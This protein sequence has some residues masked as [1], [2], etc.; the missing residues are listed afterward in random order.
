[1]LHPEPLGFLTMQMPH[2]DRR[3]VMISEV[4]LS[5]LRGGL[6][7]RG[8]F[9]PIDDPLVAD[10]N[11]Y[12]TNDLLQSAYAEKVSETEYIIGLGKPFP[13][14]RFKVQ[15][16][17]TPD[18][19]GQFF[20]IVE[21]E[22]TGEQAKFTYTDIHEPLTIGGIT[23]IVVGIAGGLCALSLIVGLIANWNCKKVEVTYGFHAS[24]T[25]KEF[26]IGCIVKCL[27]GPG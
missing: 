4:S 9:S 5:L 23:I 16:H 1:M 3:Y 6:L 10:I 11:M 18:H 27:D 22:S 8:P 15:L 17:A 21:K 25:A 13:T 12:A 19:H 26:G 2:E 14:E 7:Y 20:G 24:W